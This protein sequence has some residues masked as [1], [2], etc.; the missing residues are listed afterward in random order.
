VSRG[1][2]SEWDGK[3]LD[4]GPWVATLWLTTGKPG[5]QRLLS[6]TP[7]ELRPGANEVEIQVPALLTLVV[8]V[9]GATAET[10]V[11]LGRARHPEPASFYEGRS[12]SDGGRVEFADLPPGIYQLRVTPGPQWDEMIVRVPAA[13]PVTYAPTTLRGLAVRI[14]DASGALA[15]AGFRDGD[16]VVRIDGVP[17]DTVLQAERTAYERSE[18]TDVPIEVLRDG[19]PVALTMDMT[20]FLRNADPGGWWEPVLP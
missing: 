7:V 4:P 13:E 2:D 3:S 1:R 18:R 6:S 5:P 11:H 8:A 9:P 10:K 14:T 16:V 17:A 19:Q 12:V 15:K 20:K